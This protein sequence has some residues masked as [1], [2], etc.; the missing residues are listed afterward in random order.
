[1]RVLSAMT[2]VAVYLNGNR[3]EYWFEADDKEGWVDGWWPGALGTLTWG[4]KK[5]SVRILFEG[6]MLIVR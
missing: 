1:M 2:D 3:V 6:R 4:R 5:G